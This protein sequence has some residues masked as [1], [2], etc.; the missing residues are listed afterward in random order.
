MVHKTDIIMEQILDR[1][2]DLVF[3][4]ETWLTSDCN[5]VTAMVKTYGYEILH[6]RRKNREKETGGGVGVLVKL[7]IKRKP[8]KSKISKRLF[9][10]T[11]IRE[12]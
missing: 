12:P 5:H 6:C 7:N 3:L 8:L 9:T 1:D 10:E 4:T 11:T 2:S